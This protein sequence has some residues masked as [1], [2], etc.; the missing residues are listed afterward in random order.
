MSNN[1]MLESG[2]QLSLI[3]E[4][5]RRY[6]GILIETNP[7]AG[8]KLT[9]QQGAYAKRLG[10]QAGTLDLFL[11]EYRTYIELKRVKGGRLSPAQK[12]RIP[13]LEQSGY[14]VI[15]GYGAIDALNKFE[16]TLAVNTGN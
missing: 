6:P 1:T 2:E 3:Q 9:K 11:P 4:L 14:T 8:A 13:K 10:Y 5:D 7:M 15:V 12:E 16:K